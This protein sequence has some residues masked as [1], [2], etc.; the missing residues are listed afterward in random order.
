[1]QL[2]QLD[3]NHQRPHQ[4]LDMAVPASR[5]R[6]NG[7]AR[8]VA[9]PQPTPQDEQVALP[10]AGEGAVAPPPLIRFCTCSSS[11]G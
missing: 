4:T 10:W 7:P 5:F 1:M 11:V 3:I 6:P 8:D 2:W 9:V